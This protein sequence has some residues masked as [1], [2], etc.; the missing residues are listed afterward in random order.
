MEVAALVLGIISAVLV[1]VPVARY[2]AFIPAIIA[3]ILGIISMVKAKKKGK[4]SGMGL[5]G[6]ITGAFSI[7]VLVIRIAIVVLCIV[8]LISGYNFLDENGFGNMINES[9]E[10]LYVV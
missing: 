3:I 7:I 8:A 6:I 4:F 10:Q 5:T 9:F 1:F 2:I